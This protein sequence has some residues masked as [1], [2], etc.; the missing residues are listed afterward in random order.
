MARSGATEEGAPDSHECNLFVA[1][2]QSPDFHPTV[3][4]F[5]FATSPTRFASG[6]GTKENASIPLLLTAVV[7]CRMFT[8]SAAF[9]D[10]VY[11]FKDYVWECERLGQII[12]EQ[13]PIAETLLDVA[14]GT[15]MHLMNLKKRF[16]CDGFDLD[17]NLLAIAKARNPECQFHLGDMLNLKL[18]KKY[19]V[20]TCLFSSIGYAPDVDSMNAAINQ[21]GQHLKKGG[22]LIVEPWLAPEVFVDGHLG[23]LYVDKDDF[24]L[25][26]IHLSHREG[27]HSILN[28]HYLVGTPAGVEHAE[29]RHVT[30]LFTH[31]EYLAAFSKAGLDVVHDPE[32]LMGRGLYLGQN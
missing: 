12:D 6:E 21:M 9:Y 24:K 4:A 30:T 1:W 14:C 10:A 15:G 8:K 22:L 3:S 32:G 19:D 20:I 5:A 13:N 11:A 17:P 2:Q 27:R 26:R 18:E 28:F 16:R 25:A 29:E 7:Q 23:S 31:D